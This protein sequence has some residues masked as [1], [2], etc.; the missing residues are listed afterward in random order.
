MQVGHAGTL[1]PA[2]TGLLIV[3]FGVACKAVSA[4]PPLL[5]PVGLKAIAD[6]QWPPEARLCGPMRGGRLQS[7][8]ELLCGRRLTGRLGASSKG[9][10]ALSCSATTSK[11]L[12][13]GKPQR[14]RER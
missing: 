8:G 6:R 9:L 12:N 2:A 13:V 3:C 10:Q 14:A 7:S 4:W 5:V 11:R 1:D